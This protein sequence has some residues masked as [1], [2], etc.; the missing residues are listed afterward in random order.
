MTHLLDQQLA[1]GIRG[2]FKKGWEIAQLLPD[3]DPRANFNR[4]WYLLQQGDLQEG[5]RLL[6]QGRFLNVFGNR[7]IGTDKPIWDGQAQGTILLNLEGGLG[8]QVH[9]VRWAKDIEALGNN[10]VVVSCSFE[11]APLFVDVEGVSAVVSHEAALG[12]YHDFWLPSMSAVV[13]L[14]YEYEDLGGEAYISKPWPMAEGAGK[15]GLR[16][17]G[18]P[19]FEHEQHRKFPTELLFGAVE[20][21]D[22]ISLQR[23]DGADLKP[24]WVE[25][26]PLDNWM[27]TAR[28]IS[29]CDLVISSCTSVAHLSAAMG[30][31]TW[32]MIPILPYYLWAMPGEKSAYY[33]GVTLFRQEKFQDWAAPFQKIR[34]RLKET[35]L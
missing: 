11:L 22:C 24:D 7:H 8:D 27:D 21:Q 3:D 4:G 1:A 12:V 9:G 31:P 15:I 28:A 29:S 25:D 10:K 2:D 6:D 17:S 5:H 13:A 26:V 35:H 20:G 34:T 32:I 14:G 23:D 16:W 19:Q 30:V 33:D 18:N